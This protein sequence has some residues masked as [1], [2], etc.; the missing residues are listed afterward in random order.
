M[1][2]VNKLA[3]RALSL[4]SDIQSYQKLFGGLSKSG[5]DMDRQYAPQFKSALEDVMQ[6][7]PYGRNLTPGQGMSLMPPG[8][9]G[10]TGFA[11]GAAAAARD[12]GNIPFGLS[13]D[14]ERLFGTNPERPSWQMIADAGGSDVGTQT[15][16]WLPCEEGMKFA[17]QGSPLFKTTQN[18]AATAKPD[19]AS[20][21]WYLSIRFWRRW[22]L[23]SQ[24]KPPTHV[25]R[26]A[27]AGGEGGRRPIGLPA[28]DGW[29]EG[30]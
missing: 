7:D 4:G 2:K 10:G 27:I 18:L 16:N 21:P 19:S 30:L 12:A 1:A 24:T 28:S 26:A 20:M 25:R 23:L 14:T 13:Q 3:D 15:K 5:N 6:G 11:T 9:L 17:P 22:R 8:P 29:N